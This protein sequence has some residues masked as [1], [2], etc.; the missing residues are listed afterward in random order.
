M[1]NLTMLYYRTN[2]EVTY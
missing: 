2:I 1:E